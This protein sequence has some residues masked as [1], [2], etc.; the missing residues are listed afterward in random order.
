MPSLSGKTVLITG[1]SGTVGL[2]C[3]EAFREAGAQ[4][5]MTDCEPPRDGV[6]DEQGAWFHR[7]DITDRRAVDEMFDAAVKRFGRIDCA[8]LA[9]GTEGAVGPVEGISE[10]DI[11]TVLAVN[12]KGT[13]FPMQ[14]CL[15]HMKAK[16]GGAIVALSSISGLVGAASLAPYV[17]SKHAVV[18]LVR[19]AALE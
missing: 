13:L 1:A 16:G 6:L 14:A 19:A 4:V 8:V 15:A 3:L 17:I 9:A 10:A 2:A 7:A 11:D 5:A 12:V 18:G